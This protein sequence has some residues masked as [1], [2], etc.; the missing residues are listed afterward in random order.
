MPLPCAERSA[1]TTARM[2]GNPPVAASGLHAQG[3]M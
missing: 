3:V 2:V 1:S